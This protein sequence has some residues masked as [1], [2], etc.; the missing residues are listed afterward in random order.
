MCEREGR[1]GENCPYQMHCPKR[2]VT[3]G[4]DGKAVCLNPLPVTGG[5][6]P[7]EKAPCCLAED[8]KAGAT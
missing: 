7:A 5:G 1:G 3:C 4:D 6:E 2:C 8:Y